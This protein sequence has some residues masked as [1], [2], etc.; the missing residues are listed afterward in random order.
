M[1]AGPDGPARAAG[2]D[3]GESLIWTMQS[4]SASPGLSSWDDADERIR[5][6]IDVAALCAAY[7]TCAPTCVLSLSESP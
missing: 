5:H 3:T 2:H 4:P 1:Q 7:S 6:S